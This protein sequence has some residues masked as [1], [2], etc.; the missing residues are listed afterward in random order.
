MITY[1]GKFLTAEQNAAAK[2]FALEMRAS[3]AG[4]VISDKNGAASERLGLEG[5]PRTEGE[6]AK[7]QM[8]RLVNAAAVEAGLAPPEE[9]IDEDGDEATNNYG[10][11]FETMEILFWDRHAK[12]ADE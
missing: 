8:Q 4:M 2:G 9:F 12:A 6:L 1:T 5:F 3:Y 10:A 7:I 11:N